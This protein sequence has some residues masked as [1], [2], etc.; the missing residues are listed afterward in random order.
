MAFLSRLFGQKESPLGLDFKPRTRPVGVPAATQADADAST[1]P[2]Q[3]NGSDAQ[4]TAT[5]VAAE[6]HPLGNTLFKRGD[7]IKGIFLV[8]NVLAGGMGVVYICRMSTPNAQS[9]TILDIPDPS[10]PIADESLRYRAIKSFRREFLL[11]REVRER[12]NNEALLW[13]SLCPHPNV[14]RAWTFEQAAPLL[15]LEY[16]DGGD[17]RGRMSAPLDPKEVARIA[18]QFCNGM[19]FLFESAGIIHRDI[20]PANILLTRDGTV[21]IT[22]FGLARAF[23]GPPNR[24]G[25]GG[26]DTR[27]D[28]GFVAQ[29]GKIMGSLPWMSPEQFTTPNDVTVA[30][31]VY[32]FGVVLYEMLTGQM[33]FIA[34]SAKEWI[35][36]VLHEIPASPASISGAD[37][38]ASAIAMKCLGKKPEHRFK[39]FVD[40]R[41]ALQ[42]WA[43]RMGWS[44]S[45][46]AVD[47]PGELEAAMT[48]TDWAG[49]GYAFGQLRRNEDS[50][51]SYLRVLDLDPTYHGIHTNI[52]SALMRLG[53]VEEGIRHYEK[54]VEIHPTLALAWESLARGYLGTKRLPEAVDASRRASELA[55]G[56]IGL[57]RTY[58]FAARRA[59]AMPDYQRAVS[60]V[61][62][63]LD[64]AAQDNPLAAINEAIQFMQ[65]GDVQTG[66]EMHL[67][68]IQKYPGAAAAWYNFGVTM[69]RG[70]QLDSAI[71]FYSRAI[72]LDKGRT[73]AWLYRG[74]IRAGRGENDLARSDWQAAIASDPN[75][76][77]S[78]AVRI[79]L[80]VNFGPQL[81]ECLDMLCAPAR[82]QYVI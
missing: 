9:G 26:T 13:V 70:G 72:Q 16:V 66:L 52:G 17:L 30:S 76:D 39:D 36:K 19:I 78:Q 65:D 71:D 37:E 57:A 46:P 15:F 79:L 62:T 63:L 80:Q 22:D 45:I 14:V 59:G 27:S 42:G 75:S 12:F 50:Y 11:N 2:G 7:L 77:Y 32:S 3:A 61:K 51:Q 48:P 1:T 60:A 28:A 25:S 23:S 55:P 10:G 4:N 18:L 69:H 38:E 43:V 81:R 44:S 20:K 29:C 21:K 31:D 35:R 34:S 67:R 8:E 53:R 24:T 6:H 47:A 49:R 82:L 73:L 68:S 74:A 58:A 40:L 56:H 33:P 5:L 64:Q 54:E 41:Q